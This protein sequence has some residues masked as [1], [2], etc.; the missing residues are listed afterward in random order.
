[1][2]YNLCYPF[3]TA[4]AGVGV[5]VVDCLAPEFNRQV[6]L[7]SCWL[8]FISLDNGVFSSS[9]MLRCSSFGPPE[10]ETA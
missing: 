1:M 9:I 7:A 5:W 8:I 2:S 3:D 6:E 10:E 4:D